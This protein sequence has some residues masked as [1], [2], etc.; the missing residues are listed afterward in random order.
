MLIERT[1]ICF[2]CKE[3]LEEPE[4]VPQAERSPCPRCG[5]RERAVHVVTAGFIRS[6][7]DLRLDF[8]DDAP[9]EQGN[10]IE[11]SQLVIVQ[12][13]ISP[14]RDSYV[15]RVEDESTGKVLWTFESPLSEYGQRS[16]S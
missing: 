15:E 6:F 12:R 2:E 7:D 14:D 3:V 4:N 9:L 10:E 1:V 5:S 13:E 11:A 16:E 8:R